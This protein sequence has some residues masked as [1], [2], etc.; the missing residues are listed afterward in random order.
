MSTKPVHT[1]HICDG[2]YHFQNPE[3]Y[4]NHQC[5]HHR[6]TEGN[7]RIMTVEV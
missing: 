1:I 5:H 6:V 4:I 7:Q 2:T 3:L